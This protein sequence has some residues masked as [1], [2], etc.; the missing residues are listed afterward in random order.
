MQSEV[1]QRKDLLMAFKKVANLSQIPFRI[2]CFDNSH[3]G[4]ALP[5]S[6]MVVFEQGKP[7]KHA[8]RRFLIKEA[9]GGDDYGGMR[10]VLYRRFKRGLQERNEGWELPQLLIVDG[11]VGQLNVAMEVLDELDVSG[12][13]VI[14]VVKPCTHRKKRGDMD[15]P[16]RIVSPDLIEPVQLSKGDPVLLFLQRIRDELHNTAVTYQKKQREKHYTRSDLDDV[17]GVGPKTKKALLVHFGSCKS[18]C[19]RQPR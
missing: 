18:H 14:G 1:T 9:E 16:D 17:S 4:G 7:N 12:V 2:E 8:Y 11:G 3:L 15:M 19:Q 5:V 10:E 13:D 6:A